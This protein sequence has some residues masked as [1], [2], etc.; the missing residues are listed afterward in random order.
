MGEQHRFTV[1][2]FPLYQN[3][4]DKKTIIIVNLFNFYIA[5]F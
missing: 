4:F 2:S 3:I 5:L 1:A